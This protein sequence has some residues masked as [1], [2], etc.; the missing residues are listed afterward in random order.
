MENDRAARDKN[1]T[2]FGGPEKSQA[3]PYFR[4]HIVFYEYFHGDNGAGIGASHQTGW[5]GLVA[6]VIQLNAKLDKEM[7][8]TAGTGALAIRK[9]LSKK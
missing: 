9:A 7:L 1:K 8:L 3:D 2:V 5:T 6:R 4:D